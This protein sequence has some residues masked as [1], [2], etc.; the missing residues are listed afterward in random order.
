MSNDETD[1]QGYQVVYRPHVDGLPEALYDPE[2][3]KQPQIGHS[4]G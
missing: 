2:W 1:I 3:M 4:N